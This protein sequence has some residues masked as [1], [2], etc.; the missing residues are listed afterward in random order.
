MTDLAEIENQSYR[1]APTVISGIGLLATFL[2]ILVALL[3]VRLAQNRIQ[4][5]D[6]LVQ[7]LSGKFLSSVVA[8]ACATILIHAEKGLT[9]P[10]R[11]AALS[12][13]STL[14]TLLPK[15]GQGQM[16]SNLLTEI[17]GQSNKLGNFKAEVMQGLKE[18]L[19][20][21]IKPALSALSSLERISSRLD[22]SQGE[23][24]RED[25]SRISGSLA[26]TTTL[27]R[28]MNDQTVKNQTLMNGFIEQALSSTVQG[29]SAMQA[30]M[31]QLTAA[32]NT[33]VD[34]LQQRTGES[35]ASVDTAL[36][37]IT[38]NVSERLLELSARMAAAI[39]ET[40][41]R[42]AGKAKEY[43]D[44]AVS[45]N[46]RS[47]EH[48]SRL[49]ERHGSE[50]TRVEDLKGLLDDTIKGFTDSI[51]KYGRVTEGLQHVFSQLG[52]GIAS[53]GETAKSIGQNQKE[54]SRVSTSLS[55][56][57]DAMRDFSLEQGQ[58]WVRVQTSMMEYEK[59]F[60]TVEGHAAEMLS[61]IARHLQ[62]YSE[63]TERHFS[64]LALAADNLVSQA[65][66]RL[67]GSIDELSEQ[68]DDL[69]SALGGM[70]RASETMRQ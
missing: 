8:V 11:E 36:T 44:Q 26:E 17:S 41:A 32:V 5:L 34:K 20:E 54:A 62:D 37:S 49:I 52:A 57:I 4:G 22:K 25:F 19:S 18:G 59:V 35:V 51:G 23:S 47:A 39:E 21:G 3:D 55:Q 42:S 30:R 28:K 12:L 29:T 70:A 40:S 68:L 67:S 15:L 16:L 64:H 10:V 48:L 58:V 61:H 46:S 43:M 53:L 33:L 50:L 14:K 31:E 24:F 56:Q 38:S 7:G 13:T 69:H 9:R 6:L 65:T 2:A 27:L 45:L 60:G 1:T 63:A 66:G